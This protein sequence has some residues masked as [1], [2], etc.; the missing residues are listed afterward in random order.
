M[1]ASV[2]MIST[3]AKDIFLWP[4]GY[5]CFK[6]DFQ[7]Q[8]RQTYAYVLVQITG[9]QWEALRGGASLELAVR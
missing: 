9:G 5:W 2:H 3:D 4:D 6:E 8:P 1:Y 7:S